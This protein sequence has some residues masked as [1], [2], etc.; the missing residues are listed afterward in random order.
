MIDEIKILESKQK[1]LIVTQKTKFYL[2]GVIIHEGDVNYGHYYS[3]VYVNGSWFKF[4]DL[5]VSKVEEFEVMQTGRGLSEKKSANCYCLVYLK[6][7][8]ANYRK[9]YL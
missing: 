5:Q 7:K 3:Y 9:P 8:K 6:G 4:D 2:K 1:N